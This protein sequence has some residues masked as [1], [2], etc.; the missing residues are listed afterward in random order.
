MNM[1][2]KRVMKEEARKRAQ[3]LDINIMPNDSDC[4]SDDYKPSGE[5]K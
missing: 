1:R 3:D 4:N 2:E 5:E